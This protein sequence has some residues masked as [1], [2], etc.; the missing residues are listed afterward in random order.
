MELL[1]SL[2]SSLR[3]VDLG[4]LDQEYGVSPSLELQDASQRAGLN[5]GLDL[6]LGCG[7][8]V[9]WQR[10]LSTEMLV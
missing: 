8:C 3:T 6:S 4:T 5:L 7:C 9:C 10:V 1:P 2:L